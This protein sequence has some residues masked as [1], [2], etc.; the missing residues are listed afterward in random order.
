MHY[1]VLLAFAYLVI[2]LAGCQTLDKLSGTVRKSEIPPITAAERKDIMD[3]DRS[4]RTLE[5]SGVESGST[6]IDRYDSPNSLMNVE[7]ANA[8]ELVRK[9]AA[10]FRVI[11][12]EEAKEYA[13]KRELEGKRLEDEQE[14][15]RQQDA[16][17]R[18]YEASPEAQRL[19]TALE[20]KEKRDCIVNSQRAID[21][22]R[23]IGKISG[24]VDMNALYR[25]GSRITQ[26]KDDLEKI[27]VRCKRA[28][29]C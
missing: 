20:I 7:D 5:I 4:G 18:A 14:R 17:R 22:Q 23:E 16:A 6:L 11:R 8:L 1:R 15:R 12:V 26:C 3:L 9:G 19:Q 21:H 29:T 10:A 13:R 2:V 27:L 24:V 28:K 25:A